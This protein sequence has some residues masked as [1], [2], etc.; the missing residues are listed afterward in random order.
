ML[1]KLNYGQ[2]DFNVAN[3][4]QPGLCREVTRAMQKAVNEAITNGFV[5][6]VGGPSDGPGYFPYATVVGDTG[7]CMLISENEN[8]TPNNRVVI[9]RGDN[10]GNQ[11]MFLELLWGSVE[12]NIILRSSRKLLG[13]GSK[14]VRNLFTPTDQTS[15]VLSTVGVWSSK[16]VT[17]NHDYDLLDFDNYFILNLGGD[18]DRVESNN[19]TIE[20]AFAALVF[21]NNAPNNVWRSAPTTLQAA[22]TGDSDFSSLISKPGVSK[23]IKGYDF[24]VKKI[25]F[26][27]PKAEIKRFEI[28]FT[29]PNGE[30]Y[31]FH[32]RD[33]I[34][35][36]NI[37]ANDI[38]STNRW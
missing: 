7:S 21:D 5:V 25:S 13:Y 3:D 28:D 30:F 12:D 24:D 35:I 20:K 18:Y 32:G 31:D 19:D 8:A 10:S 37:A 11:S 34:L 22:G 9:Q 16:P 33:H 17:A 27:Q 14:M 29:K 2:Y 23:P 15:G 26:T 4:Y 36:F 6:D 38:N 1:A